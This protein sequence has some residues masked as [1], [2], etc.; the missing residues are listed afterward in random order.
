MSKIKVDL[1]CSFLGKKIRNPLVL[2]SGI[3]GTSSGLLERIAREGAGAVTAKSCGPEPR[4]GHPNPIALDWRGG[5]INA[6]GLTNP[7]VEEEVP[8]LREAKASLTA[9]GVPLMAS[10]FAPSVEEFGRMAATISRAEP[11]W[12]EVNISCPNVAD[13]FGTPF[14]GSPDTTFKVTEMVRK[15]T[16]IPVLIKLAPNVPSIARIALAAESA[17]ADGITAIN[18]VPGMLIDPYA[19]RPVLA[20]KAGGLSGWSIKPVALRCVAEICKA[21]K[22]PVL[23]LGGVTSGLDAAEMIMAGASA[24]GVG[25]AV[26]A[27]GMQAFSLIADELQAFMQVEGYPDLES[28]RGLAIR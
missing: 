14:S 28:M 6:V 23:G 18:T 27:R 4:A 9:M 8:L 26:R 7:G 17:G 19:A 25:T 5:M 20:N 24:V 15:H 2:A 22:I 3:L 11:D 12:I 13:D 10:I 16:D 1:S 21:V